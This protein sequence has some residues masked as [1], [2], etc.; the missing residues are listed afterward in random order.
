M[1]TQELLDQQKVFMDLNQQALIEARDRYQAQIHELRLAHE[2]ECQATDRALAARVLELQAREEAVTER[3]HAV[4]VREAWM[5]DAHL[6]LK[7]LLPT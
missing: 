4:S 7:A 2:L 6:K 5:A 1:T 3:E